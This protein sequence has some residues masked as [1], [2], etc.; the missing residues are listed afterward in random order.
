MENG[1]GW[2]ER[3]RNFHADDATWG[4][5]WFLFLTSLSIVPTLYS[6]VAS[7]HC[8]F[9][10]FSQCQFSIFCCSLVFA[11]PS[12]VETENNTGTIL[13][14][15]FSDDTPITR[16][17]LR[18]ISRLKMKPFSLAISHRKLTSYSE[19]TSVVWQPNSSSN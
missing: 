19:T 5:W 3:F 18:W 15:V 11:T 10:F 6:F 14:E 4:W 7:R 1:K 13:S 16:D 12:C 8:F 2:R 9:F 17:D